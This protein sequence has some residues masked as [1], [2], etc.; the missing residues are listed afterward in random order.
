MTLEGLLIL[1]FAL[2]T[3]GMIF[4][5]VYWYFNDVVGSHDNEDG[6]NTDI[7]LFASML[8]RMPKKKVRW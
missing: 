7:R 2:S 6:L 5:F 1:L 3:C 8:Q 4:W